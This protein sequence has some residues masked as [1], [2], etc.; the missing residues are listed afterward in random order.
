MADPTPPISSTADLYRP[1]QVFVVRPPR[2]RYWLHAL[3]LLATIFTTLVVGARMQFNFLHN[4]PAFS[5]NDDTLPFFPLRWILAQPSRLLLG[6]PFAATLMLILLAH[7]MGHYLYCRSYRVYATLPFFIPAPTLIGTLGAFIR[8]R[9]P[10][11]SRAAL[12]DIGIAGPIAG[13]VVAVVVL[14]VALGLSKPVPSGMAAPEIELGY[15]LIFY[16]MHQLLAASG[17]AHGIAALPFDHVFLHPTAIA[18]W[19]GMFAT[20][21]NLLPGGQLDGGHIVFS[22]APRAHRHIS[23]LTILALIP[24]AIYCWLGWLIW[25]VLLGISGMRHPVVPE[26]PGITG[27]RRWLALLALL[28]LVLTLTP[29]PFVNGSL[30]DVIREFRSAQ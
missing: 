21:L 15:P 23:R 24:M 22:F 2:Q 19:V 27:G 25:G 6:V 13:F 18:A 9:S 5:L 4:Q 1:V 26:W 20:A 3:L 17:L 10:I 30:L 29:A 8:I 16:A 28:M 11:R 12:F 7:E 14:A